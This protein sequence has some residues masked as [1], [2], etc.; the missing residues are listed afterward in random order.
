[1]QKRRAAFERVEARL[2]TN[3]STKLPL[4]YA[5]TSREALYE[6][7]LRMGKACLDDMEIFGHD[8]WDWITPRFNL[9]NAR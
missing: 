8:L 9:I 4:C 5:N 2:G 3:D 7:G 1:M 6:Q